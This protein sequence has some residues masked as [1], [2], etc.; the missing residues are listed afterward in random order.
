MLPE[1]IEAQARHEEYRELR[2][3]AFASGALAAAAMTLSM[4][5]MRGGHAGGAHGGADPLL[6]WSMRWLDPL[7]VAAFPWLYGLDAA[8]LRYILLALTLVV[9][10]WAGREYYTRAWQAFRLRTAGMDTLIAAG[11]GAALLYSAAVTAAPGFF[12]RHG[13]APDVYYEA[14]AMIIA[15]VLAGAA[16]ESR[17]RGNT[18]AALKKM[19]ALQPAAARVIR[20]G[21]ETTL[22]LEQVQV[23]DLIVLRPGERV[24]VDGVVVDG[25]SS[26]DESMLTGE[27]LPVG[28]GPGDRV[29]GGTLNRMGS[30]RYRV[31]A[32]G[33]ASALARIVKLMREAQASRAP[34]EKLADRVSAI[35]VP[36]VLSIA[37]ATFAAW[38]ILAP[39]AGVLRALSAA[40]A[41]L[42]IACPCAVGLAVPAAIIAAT[43]RGASL[44]ILFKGGEAIEKLNRVDIV[45]LDKTGT[46]TEGR[47]AVTD[48]VSSVGYGEEAILSFV[49]A[50]EKLSEHPLAEAVVA[51]AA[52]RGI[53]TRKAAEF[54]AAPG[55]GAEALVDG[56]RVLAGNEQWLERHGI[57]TSGLRADAER[58]AREGK[59]PIYA[60]IG[61]APA[62]LIAVADPVKPTSAAAVRELRAMGLEVIMAT[63]DRPSTAHAIARAVGVDRV[64]AGVLPEGKVEAVKRLQQQG[65][66]VAMAGD[67]VN[68]APGLAQADAGL[69]MAS[70]SDIAA[71]AADA[72]LMRSDLQA[73]VAAIR[74]ARRAVRVMRQNLAWAFLY[75]VV[76]I[77]VAAG[78]LYPFFGM[79]LS[80]VLAG[81]AMALSSVSVV[82]NSLRL[83]S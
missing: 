37:I 42:I 15:L 35:F 23:G 71:E 66:V 7:L 60:A 70:G 53:A 61:G 10:G 75:N 74:L 36:V 83:R 68:D 43:G 55:L 82:A 80:P 65:R 5:L 54:R 34:M 76:G 4:P 18:S 9:A 39:E 58:V 16:V 24:A 77:P 32:V 50:V 27:P 62:G 79:L 29:T 48:I 17:V 2:L 21:E 81:A 30:L 6:E 25:A 69:A 78:V 19:L 72:T 49:A 56:R 41:V 12:V 22:P 51:A 64:I 20:G 59:T 67:G 1:D 3:K 63:G 57:P 8:M 38:M 52:S 46:I 47:P 14:V 73:A 28:K 13:V 40:V 26:V 11:T 31:E 44:G 33:P 45:V